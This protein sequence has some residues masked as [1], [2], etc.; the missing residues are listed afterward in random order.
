M[1]WELGKSGPC[2]EWRVGGRGAR[3]FRN[4]RRQGSQIRRARKGPSVTGA[5]G[6]GRGH[7]PMLGIATVWGWIL[8]GGGAVD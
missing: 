1:G 4:K 6:R 3:G 2:R 5:A 7:F 8:L